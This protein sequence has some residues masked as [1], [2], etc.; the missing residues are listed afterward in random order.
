[1]PVVKQLL[2][3]HDYV[4]R[5]AQ[6][7]RAMGGHP[8]RNQQF[9]NIARLKREYLASD[10]PVVSMD[11]KKKELIGNFYRA[12]HLLTQGVIE[13]STTT[14]PASPRAWSSR[15]GCTT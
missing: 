3:K 10:D 6:K 5:K 7:S 11:T 4:T 15:T 14:S 9:E 12:G 2:D 1:M 8:D 13:T